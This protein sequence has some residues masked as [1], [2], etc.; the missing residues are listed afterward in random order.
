MIKK[1]FITIM[2]LLVACLGVTS[3]F[4]AEN[5][6]SIGDYIGV[7]DPNTATWALGN[8]IN[9]IIIQFGQPGF[10][11]PIIG[12]WNGD[13]FSDIGV[14]DNLNHA[15][16]LRNDTE[17]ETFQLGWPGSVPI[18][19]KSKNK[20]YIGVYDSFGI[21]GQLDENNSV[22]KIDSGY[23]DSILLT[24]DWDGSGDEELGLYNVKNNTFMLVN[25]EGFTI[26]NLGWDG[27][28]PVVGDWNGTGTDTVGVFDPNTATWALGDPIAPV[29]IQFGPPGQ[30]QPIIGDWDNDGKDDLGVYVPS[31]NCFVISVNG[32]HEQINLGWSG[33][34]P[35]VGKWNVSLSHVPNNI[36]SSQ[37]LFNRAIELYYAGQYND[38]LTEMDKALE[39]DSQNTTILITKG[40]MLYH[41]NRFEE[42]LQL[43][44]DSIA[45]DSQDP[46]SWNNKGLALFSL[47]KYEESFTAY[48]QSVAIDPY[49]YLA[50]NNIGWNFYNLN[51]YQEAI[52]AYDV[53]LS[54]NSQDPLVWNNK[55][56]VLTALGR[57]AEAEYYSQK[58]LE[59]ANNAES[60]YNV[61]T[62]I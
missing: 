39:T 15:F 44:E 51:M 16:S 3:S 30:S 62:I 58:A 52:N 8:P 4:A 5:N 59:L 21:W 43:Y 20:T 29:I 38:A 10:S 27:V 45:I 32:L 31:S 55:S 18:N 12:D 11:K 6:S 25:N 28:I 34:I 50:W 24:G 14:Y 2:L 19:I 41:Q 33:V 49:Y 35:V 60:T 26:V 23:P 17:I 42:S 22:E 54:I 9:P 7:F 56:L 1:I 40:N 61:S 48:N 46:V 53:A 37:I 13:G 57:T 47:G 36:L